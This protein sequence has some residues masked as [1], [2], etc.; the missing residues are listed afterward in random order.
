M[1]L[2]E[3]LNHILM[4]DLS[5]ND[6]GVPE[7]QFATTLDRLAGRNLAQWILA[8]YSETEE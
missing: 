7:Y 6:Q 2:I 1:K 3:P 8:L 4:N 5:T